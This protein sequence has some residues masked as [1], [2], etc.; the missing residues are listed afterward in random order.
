MFYTELNQL[1]NEHEDKSFLGKLVSSKKEFLGLEAEINTI[2]ENV[3]KI[4]K[5]IET[6]QSKIDI[7]PPRT[8]LYSFVLY[9]KVG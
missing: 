2:D 7:T 5:I 3:L 4:E 8:V 6:V 9:R 1:K